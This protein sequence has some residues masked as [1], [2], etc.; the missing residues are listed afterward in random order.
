MTGQA[1][2][3][4]SSAT[5]GSIC[6]GPR[7]QLVPTT[8]TPIFCMVSA[9]MVGVEPVRL[10]PCS[11]VIE[12]MT[13]RSHSC[14]AATT[15]ALAS[16]RSNWVSIKMRSTP[17]ATRPRICWAKASISSRGSTGPRG[18]MKC[19]VGPTLPATKTG[20]SPGRGTSAAA[21]RATVAMRLLNAKT[22]IPFGSL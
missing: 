5:T 2:T 14:R 4:R 3:P 18:F 1:Q 13:G 6:S 12:T 10:T 20:R 17:P 15:A 22:S 9:K 8:S 21:A 19:P 7:L 11:N 16:A